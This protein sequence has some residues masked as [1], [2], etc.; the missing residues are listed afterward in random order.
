M[1]NDEI[2]NLWAEHAFWY[3][4]Q[5]WV[6]VPMNRSRM[7]SVPIQMVSVPFDRKGLVLVPIKVVLVPMLSTALIFLSVHR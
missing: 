4:Y 1:K 5:K 7:V 6:S 3:R 2:C